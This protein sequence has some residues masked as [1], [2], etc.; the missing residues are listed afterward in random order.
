MGSD[1]DGNNV[2]TKFHGDG[3]NVETKQNNNETMFPLANATT[4]SP[5]GCPDKNDNDNCIKAV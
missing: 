1:G 5:P 4:R 2:E 3:N